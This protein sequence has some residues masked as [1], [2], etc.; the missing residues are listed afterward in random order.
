M[1]NSLLSSQNN[2]WETPQ[3][4]FK[5]LNDKYHFSFD[6][7]ASP[8]NAKCENF[9]SEED[10]SLTKC[11]HELKGNLFLNPP[12]GRELRKWVKKAY[13]ESLKKHDGYIVLL[14]PART[15]TS[16]WHD[17]IFGKAQINFLRGRIKFELHG[18]S[19]G[20]APFPSAIIIYGEQNKHDDLPV[21]PRTIAEYINEMKSEGKDIWDAMH[22]LLRPKN[23]DEYME[24]NSETFA[25][26]WLD[27]YEVAEVEE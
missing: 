18:E 21:V 14:I 26:A 8:E 22:Y 5:N 11:W 17:F 20:T 13:E 19:K 1:N 23:V 24:D 4:F 12:Y 2:Y 15:D 16:Y 25:R 9:F 27:G 6:L 7:A 3:D 10:N